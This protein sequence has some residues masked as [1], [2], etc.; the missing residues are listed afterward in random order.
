MIGRESETVIDG[1]MS[2]TW[3]TVNAEMQMLYVSYVL[4]Y[5]AHNLAYVFHMRERERDVCIESVY[6]RALLGRSVPRTGSI[7]HSAKSHFGRFR[8]RADIIIS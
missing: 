7:E 5:R 2:S 3:R 6:F 1:I 4:Q 8:M